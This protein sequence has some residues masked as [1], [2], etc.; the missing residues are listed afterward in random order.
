MHNNPLPIQEDGNPYERL[1]RLYGIV[2]SLNSIFQLDSLLYQIVQSAAEMMEAHGGAL[3]L[4]DAQGHNLTFEV[5]SG[6]SSAQLKGLVVPIDEKSV[7]GSVALSGKPYIENDTANSPYFSGAVD[8]QTGYHTRKLICVPLKVQNRVTGVV[9][10]LDK[11]S[12]EDFN[13]A[14][15]QLLE[16]MADAAA[17]AIENVRLYEEERRKSLLLTQAYDELHNTYKATLQALTGLLDTRD[18]ATHG[19]STRV[20]D[21]ALRL[22]R[23]MGMKDHVQLKA[24]EQGALLHDV[25]KIGVAD[26]ILRKPGPLDEREWAEMRGHPELGHKMLKDI[27]FLHDALPIVRHHHENWDGTGYPDRLA[28]DEIPINA[29]IFAVIDSFDAITSDRPYSP[30]RSYKEAVAILKEERGKKL[31]P[32]IVDSFLR[33]PAKEWARI[34]ARFEGSY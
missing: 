18:A 13:Q 9:E 33:V 14:D 19:H 11:R 4:A 34:R 8:K 17:V 2:R 24:L 20:V 5:A 30:A 31:D 28:G 29:R 23:E 10:V 22:A 7:A 16:A 3:M 6:A 1:L 32:S 26:A 12:G 15:L 25:G 27:D 21:F